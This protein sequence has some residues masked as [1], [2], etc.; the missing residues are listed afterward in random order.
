[1]AQI[2]TDDLLLPQRHG[3]HGVK[4]REDRC[5]SLILIALPAMPSTGGQAG[6]NKP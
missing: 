5:T 3:G 4:Y 1:M 6:I 2:F